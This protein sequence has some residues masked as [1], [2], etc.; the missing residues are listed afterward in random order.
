MKVHAVTDRKLK[1][2]ATPNGWDIVEVPSSSNPEKKYRVDVTLGRC[3]CPAWVFQ[4]GS[5]RNLC[6]H[7]RALGFKQLIATSDLEFQEKAKAPK[8]KQKVTA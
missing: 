2:Q 8:Q 1:T 5:T 7:L 4:K 3:S 6:K